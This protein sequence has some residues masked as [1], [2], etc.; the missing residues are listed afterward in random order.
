MSS[1]FAGTYNARDTGGM[2]LA[3]G[4]TTRS[5]VL[6]RSDSLGTASDAGLESLASTPIGVIVDFRTGPEREQAPDRLPVSRSITVVEVPLLEGAMAAPTS[7]GEP[8]SPEAMLAALSQLPTMPE[9]YVGMLRHGAASFAQ[10]ARLVAEPADAEHPAVLVHCTA[11]KDRTGVATALLLDAAGAEREAVVAD[12]ALS[13]SNLAGEWADAMLAR[14][15]AAGVPALPQ[16]T[17]LVTTT[18]REAIE[19]ALGW[20]DEQGGSAAYLRAGGL[21]EEHLDGLRAQLAG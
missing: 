19:A 18:P 6:Y 1:L 15:A 2:P 17:E 7:T 8:V 21:S 3:S 4:G 12:Y 9:L 10:V 11:G 13:G 16:L 5:G 20:L 14:L